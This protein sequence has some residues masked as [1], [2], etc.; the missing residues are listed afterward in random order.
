MNHL[1]NETN[2]VA[3]IEK[4]EKDRKE[5]IIVPCKICFLVF[6]NM[7]KEAAVND[8]KKH[9]RKCIEKNKCKIQCFHQHI[10]VIIINERRIDVFDAK[11]FRCANPD[12]L[13][14]C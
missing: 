13:T 1:N 5:N 9:Q 7:Q 14:L 11:C 12:V 10:K 3:S 8:F 2:E 6:E 4:H